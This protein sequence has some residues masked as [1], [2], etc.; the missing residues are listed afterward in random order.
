MALC[1]GAYRARTADYVRAFVARCENEELLR[2]IPV[3]YVHRGGLI[4]EVRERNR[5][6]PGVAGCCGA[7]RHAVTAPRAQ[8]HVV[9]LPCLGRSRA[10]KN[11]SI[12]RRDSIAE[13]QERTS[14]I[15]VRSR[16]FTFSLS[17]S[18]YP[19]S[20]VMPRSHI[21]GTEKR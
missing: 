12:D 18:R 16:P 4:T 20:T 7:R 21:Y 6:A 9:E 10:T 5:G 15:V 8:W 1:L 19:A 3:N 14:S 17:S 11:S 13:G 2:Q